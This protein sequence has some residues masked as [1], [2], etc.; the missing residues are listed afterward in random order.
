MKGYG[1]L[2][3]PLAS[4]PSVMRSPTATKLFPAKSGGSQN[5][6]MASVAKV[7]NAVTN[8]DRQPSRRQSL[9]IERGLI[10]R[11]AWKVILQGAA[12]VH[13]GLVSLV[14]RADSPADGSGA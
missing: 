8:N 2:A 11:L 14:S 1:W 4:I 13:T 5:L 6:A 3:V 7:M 10:R 9:R 12:T